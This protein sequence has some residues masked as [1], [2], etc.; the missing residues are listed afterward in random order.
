MG[1]S[2]ILLMCYLS[3]SHILWSYPPLFSPT[4]P[5]P[6]FFS[7][8][9]FFP[10]ILQ[11][12]EGFQIQQQFVQKLAI[13]EF[14]YQLHKSFERLSLKFPLL[15]NYSNTNM[16]FKIWFY[17]FRLHVESNIKIPICIHLDF[18]VLDL[19]FWFHFGLR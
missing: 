12:V 17:R 8:L 5:P 7:L 10:H 18:I 14:G 3:L 15:E 1:R 6:G 4:P 13:I 9:F 16:V 19:R 2:N 11:Y